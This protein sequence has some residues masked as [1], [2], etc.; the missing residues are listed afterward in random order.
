MSSTWRQAFNQQQASAQ[1]VAISDGVQLRSADA[2]QLEERPIPADKL[3][4]ISTH[5]LA[6]ILYDKFSML[7][8][9][10]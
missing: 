4:A 10:F 2:I 5:H 3:L 6:D 7:I 9:L 8:L 1:L